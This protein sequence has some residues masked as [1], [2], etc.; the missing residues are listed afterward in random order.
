[1][2]EWFNN[3]SPL[4]ALILVAVNFTC[5]LSLIARSRSSVQADHDLETHLEYLD[6]RI[7]ELAAQQQ[8]EGGVTRERLVDGLSRVN[9]SLSEHQSRTRAELLSSLGDLTQ[10]LIREFGD[11]RAHSERRQTESLQQ[12]QEELRSGFAL[13][14]RQVGESLHRHAQSVGESVQKL[15]QTTDQRLQRISERVEQRLNDGFEKTTAVFADVIKRLALI[16]EAQKKI[17]ELSSNVVTLQE[18]LSDKRSRGVFGEVQ[19]NSLVRNVLPEDSFAVQYTLPNDRVADCVLIMPEPTG[20]IAIDAK[21]PLE[22][23]QRMTDVALAETERVRAQRQFKQDVLKHIKDIADRYI[24]P[25]TTADGAMM[26]LPAEAVFAEIQAHHGDLVEVANQARVWLVSPTTLWAVLNTA[27]AV[28]RDAALRDHIHVIREHLALLAKDF[29][30]F[31]E[32]IDHLA[33]HINQANSDVQSVNASARK[34]T[35]RFAKIEEV[36]LAEEGEPVKIDDQ[37]TN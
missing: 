9:Q 36:R 3:W 8:Q 33:R 6:R 27:R 1:V 22:S 2:P 4:A 20:L 17:T 11:Q 29:S 25:G 28:L 35:S 14:Q 10:K 34:I 30:R 16:D 7:G 15:N 13:V 26:F 19:L 24:V 12:L 23:Y 21:F 32:R 31:Q 5:L 37:S 18:I